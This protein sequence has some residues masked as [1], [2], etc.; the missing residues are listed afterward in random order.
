MVVDDAAMPLTRAWCLFEVL[1]TRLKENEEDDFHGLWLCTN[2]GVL[3]EGK[4]GVDVA[5]RIAERLSTLRLENA[6]ASVQED[7]DMI[8]ELVAG[9][10]GG[11]PAMNQ[12]VR[13]KIY[14]ALLAMRSS[15]SAD[16]NTLLESLHGRESHTLLQSLHGSESSN[17]PCE[18]DTQKF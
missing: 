8:D 9:M 17:R 6:T 5:M 15:F 2:S 12:F 1:Q 13:H 7:K 16:F 14:N 11:F 4:A 10:P 3:H 18:V